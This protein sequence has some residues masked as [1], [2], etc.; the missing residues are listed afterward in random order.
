MVGL[1]QEQIKKQELEELEEDN[2]EETGEESTDE[3][4]VKKGDPAVALRIE[5]AKIKE[6]KS[7]NTKLLQQLET[8]KK[9]IDTVLQLEM[10]QPGWIVENAKKLGLT[11]GEAK[12][13]EKKVEEKQDDGKKDSKTNGEL[14]TVLDRIE[15]LE[16]ALM[17]VHETNQVDKYETQIE[18]AV[19]TALAEYSDD[20]KNIIVDMARLFQ[21]R[22]KM[23]IADSIKAAKDGFD[24]GYTTR[25]KR[26]AEK[27]RNKETE[28]R[29]MPSE[30][31]PEIE[32][33]LKRDVK[34]REDVEK[35][36]DE[37]ESL[38]GGKG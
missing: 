27:N 22:D 32:K 6:L 21:G 29:G 7:E 9:D 24:K 25:L 16:K 8:Q 31:S 30:T 18:K 10:N 37:L 28:R 14:K 5:R 33:F 17:Y 20:E 1:E 13:L 11:A 23:T 26:E 4:K 2:K 12:K 3:E 36:W 35:G 15:K 34:S 19:N 38:W